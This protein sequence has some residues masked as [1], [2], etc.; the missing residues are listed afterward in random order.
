M[1]HLVAS[2]HV[3]N[4]KV[5]NSE[6]YIQTVTLFHSAFPGFRV[7]IEDMATEGDK[8]VVH[9]THQA[10]HTGE[11]W[12]FFRMPSKSYGRGDIFRVKDSK[13]VEQWI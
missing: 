12:A 13:M 11:F 5:I 2:S 3:V 8:V 9:H 7:T 4:G 10:T 6:V 1:D